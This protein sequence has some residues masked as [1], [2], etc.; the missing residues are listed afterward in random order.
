MLDLTSPGLPPALGQAFSQLDSVFR[1]L[2]QGVQEMSQ[3]ELEYV[4]PAGNMNST[5]TLLAHLAY[6]DLGYLYCIK[7]ESVPADL[8]AD[9]GPD[10]SED[11]TLL[12]VTGKS[13]REL[14][15]RYQ[16]VLHMT[17]EHL[18]TLSDADVTR[19]VTIEWWSQPATVR[20]VL[21]HMAGHSMWHQGQIARLREWYKQRG[22]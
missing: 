6:I 15:D 21:W 16:Q 8:N 2:T 18:Q 19:E 10:Q 17:R 14:L 20:F 5:A 9:Y 22:A 4:G 13:V 7:G 12:P 3:A 11:G 1:R